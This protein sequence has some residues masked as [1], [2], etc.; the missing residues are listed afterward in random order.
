ARYLRSSEFCGACHDVRLFGTDSLGVRERGEHFKRL[1]NA[2]SEWKAWADAERAAGRQSASCQDCHM[3]LY[4][5]VCVSKPGAAASPDCPGG[6][7]FERRAP[8]ERARG[9]V[10]SS[11]TEPR[12]IASHWFT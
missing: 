12:S 11:S 1:R 8:G 6:Y 10:A 2:Y 7:A 9:M 5:G 4:P 3:S